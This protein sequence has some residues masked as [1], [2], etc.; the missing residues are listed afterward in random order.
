MRERRRTRRRPGAFPLA[1]LVVLAAGAC[2]GLDPTQNVTTGEA[3][4]GLSDA[5]TGLREDNA[6]LQAQLD[7]LRGVVARQDSTIARLAAATGVPLPPR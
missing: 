7:S 1:L 5:I 4:I 2:G 6:M 3:I